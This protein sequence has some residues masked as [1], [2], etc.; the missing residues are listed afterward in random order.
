MHKLFLNR[1]TRMPCAGFCFI[2][3]VPYSN[4]GWFCTNF[5]T[6]DP[7]VPSKV[8]SPQQPL[9]LSLSQFTSWEVKYSTS[10][11]LLRPQGASGHTSIQW[12][13]CRTVCLQLFRQLPGILGSIL[14]SSED[15]SSHLQPGIRDRMWGSASP[16][17]YLWAQKAPSRQRSICSR[18]PLARQVLPPV[19]QHL[20]PQ[21]GIKLFKRSFFK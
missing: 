8:W 11:P 4:I 6:K 21:L 5:Y 7:I 15:A 10:Q 20:L 9:P 12:D 2:I 14:A 18:Q 13:V 19:T 16:M 17:D 3:F 1:N